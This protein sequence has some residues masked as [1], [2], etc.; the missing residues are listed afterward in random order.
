MTSIPTNQPSS[1]TDDPAKILALSTSGAWTSVALLCEEEDGGYRCDSIAEPSGAAQSAGLFSLI[2][3]VLGGQPVAG[4][5]AV[6]FDA[7]P[8]AFTGLRIGCSVAQ[9]IG[10]GADLPLIPVGSHEAAA[11]N[12]LHRSGKASALVL[13]LNDARI[14]QVYGSLCHISAPTRPGEGP[15]ARRLVGPWLAGYGGVPEALFAAIRDASLGSSAVDQSWLLAGNAW[16]LSGLAP[17][18]RAIAGQAGDPLAQVCADSRAVAELGL[19]LFRRGAVVDPALAGPVY[20]RDK[21]ALDLDEQRR[22]RE[23]RLGAS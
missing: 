23:G 18:W 15:Q 21:V 5:S 13:V 2:D 10:L 12:A 6:A 8:G 11:W 9:G 16:E 19:T 17:G 1:R 20:V 3:G 14:G 7:G 22:L 4:L